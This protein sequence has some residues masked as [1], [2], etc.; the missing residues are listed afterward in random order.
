LLVVGTPAPGRGEKGEG[1]KKRERSLDPPLA[2]GLSDP[3]C[4]GSQKPSVRARKKKKKEEE[5]RSC[6]CR[7]TQ[8]CQAAFH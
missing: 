1:E 7:L 4:G 8:I 3:V 6:V 2:I 5:T